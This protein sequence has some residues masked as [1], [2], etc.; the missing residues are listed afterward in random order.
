[1]SWKA[2]YVLLILFTT[3]ISYFATIG[4]GRS[5]N[6]ITR[7]AY[8]I[9]SITASLGVLF[10]YKYFN[11]FGENLNQ[12][13]N[14]FKV[15]SS[16]PYFELLLPVGIS[17]Y[18]FQTLSYTIDVYF[19]K[20]D[21]EYHFGYYALYVSFFPQLVAGPIERSTRLLPQLRKTNHFDINNFVVGLKWII[22]GYFMKLVVADRL[23]LYVDAV[24]NN[25][26]NHSGTSFIVA[27]VLFAFQIYCDFAGYSSIAIGSARIM[28]YELMLNFKRPYFAQS[29]GEFWK[30]WH[31]SLSTWFRDYFYIPLGGNRVVKGRWFVNILLT[32]IVSGFWHGANWTFIIWGTLHGV[33]LILENIL[34]PV[35]KKFEGNFIPLIRI[36]IVFFLVNFAWIFFRANSISDAFYIVSNLFDL[37]RPLFVDSSTFFYAILG[38]ILLFVHDFIEERYPN[39]GLYGKNATIP[40]GL[41]YSSL[42]VIIFLIGVFNGGQFI[43]FQF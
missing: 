3:S 27:T 25:V 26:D 11:F 20:K 42:T 10:F 4:I 28:G 17:F 37:Q 40:V 30:R 5:N 2:E 43:Y 24:Y 14:I 16:V 12:L 33:Y 31:I 21:V 23:S 32:F 36:A 9:I 41:Y 7:K 15:S 18:T 6:R 22:S 38:L 1:M 13:F 29:I 8:L 39:F 19:K 34:K 35:N